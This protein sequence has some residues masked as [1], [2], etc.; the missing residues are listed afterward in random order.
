MFRLWVLFLFTFHSCFSLLIISIQRLILSSFSSSLRPS[1]VWTLIADFS[2]FVSIQIFILWSH[3]NCILS[4]ELKVIS[5]RQKFTLTIWCLCSMSLMNKL[6]RT[7]RMCDA[8]LLWP[9][10]TVPGD[11]GKG[12][13]LERSRIASAVNDIFWLIWF[14]LKSSF[15]ILFSIWSKWSGS[16]S[17]Q[18]YT[19]PE[20]S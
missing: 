13:A 11:M 10:Q 14:W 16:C 9:H 19:V 12:Q 4:H 2:S 17:C 8:L 6:L 5:S 18:W 15:E 7:L 3:R 1:M 20:S